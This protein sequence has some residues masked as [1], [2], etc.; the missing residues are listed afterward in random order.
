[1]EDEIGPSPTGAMT[2]EPE[3]EGMVQDVADEVPMGAKAEVEVDRDL[4]EADATPV[5]V[6]PDLAP[7]V[8]HAAPHPE[9]DAEAAAPAPQQGWREVEAPEPN[10]DADVGPPVDEGSSEEDL[11]EVA[12]NGD[13]SN[14]EAE[15]VTASGAGKR[16]R[17]L[18]RRGGS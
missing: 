9:P 16:R 14:G 11:S 12:G 5:P 8:D 6:P 4:E 1:M 10:G 18:F 7:T 13:R 2:R 17:R 3:V 15:E